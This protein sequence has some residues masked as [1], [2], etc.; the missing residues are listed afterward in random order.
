M[1]RTTTSFVVAMTPLRKWLTVFFKINW[2]ANNWNMDLRNLEWKSENVFPSYEL[3]NLHFNASNAS[4]NWNW[5][6]EIQAMKLYQ[7]TSR[8]QK[9]LKLKA[10]DRQTINWNIEIAFENRNSKVFKLVWKTIVLVLVPALV[11]VLAPV[12]VWLQ[13]LELVLVLVLVCIKLSM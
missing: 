11:L 8:G 1:R 2:Q 9:L 5:Q 6:N 13:V 10:N 7:T 3:K 4:N 12:L